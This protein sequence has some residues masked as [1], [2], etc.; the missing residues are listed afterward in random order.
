MTTATSLAAVDAAMGVPGPLGN[1]QLWGSGAALL[2]VWI[3][4]GAMVGQR[5]RSWWPGRWWSVVAA[6]VALAPA[7]AFALDV[8]RPSAEAFG[9][10]ALASADLIATVGDGRPMIV[11]WGPELA[12]SAP[13]VVATLRREGFDVRVLARARYQFGVD[14]VAEGSEGSVLLLLAPGS[15]A[16]PVLD[17][18]L[19]RWRCPPTLV[20][21]AANSAVW[22]VARRC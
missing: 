15:A 6:L 12:D 2:P 18:L 3:A 1:Y 7:A 10:Q 19:P 21:E 17:R 8:R 5:L 20:G 14:L 13:G 9:K 22:H 4:V 11:A 16:P